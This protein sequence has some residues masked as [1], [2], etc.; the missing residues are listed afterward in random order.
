MQALRRGASA[1]SAAD[2]A[3][4]KKRI[5]PTMNERV[6]EYYQAISQKFKGGLPKEVQD[7]VA[8]Q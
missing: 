6:R 4:A 8:Y 3:E 1:V 2:F 5:N 7:L